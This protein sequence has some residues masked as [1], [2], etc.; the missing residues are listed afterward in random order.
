[1]KK[2]KQV[3]KTWP[4]LYRAVKQQINNVA[5]DMPNRAIVYAVHEAIVDT[6]GIA[7]AD[8]ETLLKI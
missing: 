8:R 6:I 4:E 2:S 1:M 7:L 3:F 5:S